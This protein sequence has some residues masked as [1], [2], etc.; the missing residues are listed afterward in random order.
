MSLTDPHPV[1]LTQLDA[2]ASDPGPMGWM[3][4]SPPPPDKLIRF[5]DSSFCRF[6]RTR[7]SYSQHAPADADERR[8]RAGRRRCAR[9]HEPSGPTRRRD[10]S[11]ARPHRLDDVGAI[12]ARQLHRRHPRPAPGPHRLRALLRR[13]Q[14]RTP[15]HR[16]LGDQVVCR[17]DRGDSRST[18]ALS[19][20]T[21]TVPRYVPELEN[22]GFADATV[23]AAAR[24]DHGHAIRRGL[25]RRELLG[26][27][28]QP[29]RQLPAASCRLSGPRDR[30][31]AI[32]R[33]C[34]RV[35]A[36]RALRLQDRQHR[37][38]GVGA[39]PRHRQDA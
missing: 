6:P 30:F 17:D 38:A 34:R 37:H 24:H 10:V 14:R 8:R 19:T 35:G 22:S 26:L 3:V 33:R 29:R 11:A 31:T 25:R 18:K 4:G 16:L 5:A 15:A 13:A 32:S 12:A 39:A 9:C 20:S 21:P 1:P 23:R 27:G 7:W 2:V 36:R 28:V